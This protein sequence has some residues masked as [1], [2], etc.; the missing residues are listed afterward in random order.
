MRVLAL[1]KYDGSVASSRQRFVQ[2]FAA[3]RARGAE[4]I[5]LPLWSRAHVDRTFAGA[6]VDVIDE[7]VSYAARVAALAEVKADVW[8][9]EGE[10]LP[11]VPATLEPRAPRGVRVVV[12]YDDAVFHKY[13]L[14]RRPFVRGLLSR[15]IDD[16]M[17]ASDVVVAGNDF[18]AARAVAAGGAD[19][20]VVPTVV[21]ADVYVARTL[22]RGP[23]FNIGWIGTP[24]TARYLR[25]I[26]Q[27]LRALVGEGARLHLVG[28]DR[29][30]FDIE[31]RCTPWR[32]DHEVDDIASFD[33][34]IM[35]LADT[36]WERGK[37]GYKLIQCM[38]AGVPVV[39]SDVGVNGNVVGA[40][41]F[42]V[43]DDVEWA[44]ALRRLRDDEGLWRKCS[45]A[46]RARVAEQFS[47][48]AVVARVVDAVLG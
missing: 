35:P 33:V 44:A 40:A 37:C 6:S 8:W 17:R 27:P 48:A 30:P 29:P 15:K 23:V 25:A 45:L 12:D 28:V 19:V 36:P 4:L 1:T 16:V 9:I 11:F 41:G 14:H 46:G 32:Q 2:F 22:S 39:A 21:D 42:V 24:H 18:I 10:L 13:D 47:R 26:E 38:A 7:A 43:H 20:R 34:G 3:L 5:H 31:A